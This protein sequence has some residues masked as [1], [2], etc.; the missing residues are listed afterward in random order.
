MSKI[1][2]KKMSLLNFKG[3][4]N[5]TIYFDANTNIYGDNGTGK[6]TIFDAFTWLLFGKNSEDK[7]DFEIKTL[8]QKNK[9]IPKIDHEVSAE[10]GVDGDI[11]TI[12]RTLR[13]KWVKTRGAL[14]AEFTG[15]E[16]LYYWNEV[17][18]SMKEF[19]N[20]VSE[21]L[22]EQV[23]KLITSPTAFN[24]MKW[25]DRRDVLVKIVGEISD[26]ELAKGNSDYLELLS[27][28]TN[29]SLDEYKKQIAATI[30]KAKD[31][32]KMIPTRID[33]VER[34]KPEPVDENFVNVIISQK[35]KEIESIDNQLQDKSAAYD[36]IIKKRNANQDE[37]F[38]LKSY[39]NS[40]R[41]DVTE[42]AKLEQ[43]TENSIVE[44]IKAKIHK[45]DEEELV[46]AQKKLNNLKSEIKDLKSAIESL[47]VKINNKRNEWNSE[48][49]K[50]FTFSEDNAVCPCCN[51]AFD[52]SDIEEKK[53]SLLANFNSEK[54]KKL[55]TISE[56]GKSLSNK[57]NSA[58]KELTEIQ[59]RIQKGED[60]IKKIS[61]EIASLRS[62]LLLEKDKN[63]DKESLESIVVK[64]LSNNTEYNDLLSKISELENLT[65]ETP[66]NETLLDE[67]FS[68]I[69]ELQSLRDS[70][71]SN[72]QI[73]NADNRIAELQEEES[74][75]A[76]EIANIEKTQYTI[77]NFIKL[78]VDTIENRINEKFSLVKFKLFEDQINGGQVETCEALVNGVPFSS[79]NTASKI[80]AGIDIINTLCEFYNVS[81]PIFIDNRESVVNLLDSNSQII[82]LIVSESDKKLRI[83]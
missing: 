21:I 54:Q 27:Q 4:K 45:K 82:N 67:K 42:K 9:V 5:L 74:R 13:E 75:L 7:K 48:N 81:A 83:S 38:K 53:N 60:F 46:P 8:D 61:G 18:L 15:N 17:P 10:L 36:E 34:S 73:K 55:A 6:T 28:L 30:K 19:Q 40:I 32:I 58:E 16:T 26:D 79:L 22:D 50:Q 3:I 47:D 59:E 43:K 57:K 35:E 69:K 24:A 1:T 64:K 56:E 44:E 66:N 76:Q 33:E 37:I 39:L 52:S 29:K 23:F 72:V 20:K 25:Q 49:S 31:D 51:R 68:L 63:S 65:F 2:L 70:F 14:E 12:K 80:N 77:E 62:D 71:Q 41:F 11:I 78:K